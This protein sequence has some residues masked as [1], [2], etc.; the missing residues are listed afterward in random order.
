MWI[1]CTK[2][3]ATFTSAKGVVCVSTLN[4]MP[5]F[6]NHHL[7]FKGITSVL[8][9]H[10][11]CSFTSFTPILIQ[12]SWVSCVLLFYNWHS[13]DL[14]HFVTWSFLQYY[15]WNVYQLLNVAIFQLF[16]LLLVL[17]LWKFVCV[18]II[19]QWK[20]RFIS[21]F[22]CSDSFMTSLVHVSCYACAYIS[23]ERVCTNKWACCVMRD[24]CIYNS[25]LRIS[26][27]LWVLIWLN[28]LFKS[29]TYF[30]VIS[31]V[32]TC[33]NYQA[34]ITNMLE[35]SAVCGFFNKLSFLSMT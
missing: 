11:S 10:E 5:P 3:K 6:S 1:F 7:E 30:S 2:V 21:I 32:F 35:G 31:F 4:N 13:Y 19:C 23:P 20:H 33:M 26:Y 15:T 14:Y 22:E 18:C 16:S 27:L 28:C 12:Y 9:C 17:V 25:E 24:T 29:L 8:S 34:L